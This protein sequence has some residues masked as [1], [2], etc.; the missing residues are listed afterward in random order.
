MPMRG[1]GDVSEEK[2]L[3]PKHDSIP[4]GDIVSMTGLDTK[5]KIGN[6]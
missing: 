6:L 4:F 2:H 5:R 3:C 1:G